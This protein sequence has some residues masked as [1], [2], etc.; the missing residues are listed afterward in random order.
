MIPFVIPGDWAITKYH[1]AC[2][3]KILI[4]KKKNIFKKLR[5]KKGIETIFYDC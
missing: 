5:N 1:N 3:D 2:V 4:D